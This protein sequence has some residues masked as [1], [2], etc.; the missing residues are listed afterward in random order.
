MTHNT[1]SIGRGQ[2]SWRGERSQ[3]VFPTEF[4]DSQRDDGLGCVRCLVWGI[5][6]EGS[7]CIAVVVGWSLWISIH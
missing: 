4:M 1:G 7:I 3:I 5:V 6:F 2:A